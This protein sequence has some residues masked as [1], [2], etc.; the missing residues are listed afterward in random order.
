MWDHVFES[1][2]ETR[3]GL[4]LTIHVACYQRL[5][6]LMSLLYALATQRVQNF[7]VVVTH[8]G[9]DAGIRDA[10][11][12]FAARGDFPLTYKESRVHHGMWGYA[13]RQ[14]SL[15]EC[16]TPF[17]MSTNDDCWYAPVFTAAV[18]EGMSVAADLILTDMLHS[19][20]HPGDRVQGAYQPFLTAPAC[21]QCDIGSFVLRTELARAMGGFPQIHHDADGIFIDAFMQRYPT[22]HVHKIPQI[23]YVHN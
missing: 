10:V 4:P 5:T 9:A 19:H 2:P 6:A 11:H 23:L 21:F 3:A 1:A 12:A 14:Q 16:E 22:A 8:D 7:Q 15:M 13:L 20:D 18:A 17:W